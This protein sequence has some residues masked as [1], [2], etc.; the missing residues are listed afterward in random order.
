MLDVARP[1]VDFGECRASLA[2]RR[3]RNAPTVEP[4]E[5]SALRLRGERVAVR[6]RDGVAEEMERSSRR[7]FRIELAQRAGG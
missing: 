2:V 1:G 3:H 7:C 6:K 5:Q 4:I